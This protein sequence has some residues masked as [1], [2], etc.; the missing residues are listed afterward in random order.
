MSTAKLISLKSV[1][2][3]ALALCLT[4]WMSTS[5]NGFNKLFSLVIVTIVIT[6][7]VKL[8]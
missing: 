6:P 8:L 5:G 4:I 3:H 2:F 7:S 1:S